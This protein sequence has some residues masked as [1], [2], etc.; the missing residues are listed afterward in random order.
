MIKAIAIDDEPLALSVIEILC[1]K[2]QDVDLIKSFTQP[3]E[4][5]SYLLNYPI[6]LIF[7]DIQM[8][9]IT[10]INLIK[11]L[12]NKPMVIFTTAYSEYA[13][14]S[15]EVS[16]VDYLLKPINQNR[17][18]LS[19]TKAKEYHNY[20]NNKA[21]TVNSNIYIRS[22]F[23]LVK[24]PL[25]EIFYIEGLA[26]Y[27]K[28]HFKDRKFVLA[29]M[30]MKEILEKLPSSDFIRIHRSYILPFNKIDSVRGNIINMENNQF[31][32][33]RTFLEDFFKR[34]C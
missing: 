34:Y 17:F 12:K 11:G 26:D 2:N 33:G 31:T 21:V 20:L 27:L 8:P 10:G 9:S 22:E 5:L 29:R 30:T 3:R 32:I 15:Y 23:R 16:A 1:R 13:L 28:I 6:D 7:C 4:A 19:I 18:N 25:N 14:D 24:I